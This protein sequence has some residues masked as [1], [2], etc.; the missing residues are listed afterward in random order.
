[1]GRGSKRPRRPPKNAKNNRNDGNVFANGALDDEIDAYHRQRDVIPLD[2]NAA[3]GD[4]SDAEEPVFNLGGD[5]INDTESGSDDDDDDNDVDE[6]IQPNKFSAKIAR[7]KKFLKQKFGGSDDE[8]HDDDDDDDEDKEEQRKAAWGGK[9]S[10]YY[11]ADNADYELQSSDEDLPMEEEAEAVRIQKEKAKFL[12]LEDFG[13]EEADESGSD[14]HAKEKK[15]K[16][17]LDVRKSRERFN[18][19]GFRGETTLESFEEIKIDL[20]SLSKEELMDAVYSSAPELVGLLSELS[21]A[22]SQVEKLEPLVCEVKERKDGAKGK[23][24]HLEV[25]RLLLLTYCQAIVFYLLLKSEGHP[26]QDHPVVGRLVEIKAMMEQMKQIEANIPSQ[27]DKKFIQ[28]VATKSTDKLVNQSEVTNVPTKTHE[29]PVKVSTHLVIDGSLKKKH[30]K[31]VNQKDQVFQGI[32]LQSMEML[33]VRADLEAKLK[34]KGLYDL[35]NSK[36][37][38]NQKNSSKPVNKHLETQDDFDDEVQPVVNSGKQGVSKLSKLIPNKGNK[39]KFVSGDDDLP[40][41]DDIGERR[42]KHELRVLARA[43]TVSMDDD[44]GLGNKSMDIDAHKD[45]ETTDPE[46]DFYKEVKRQRMEKLNAKAALYSRTPVAPSTL[47]TEEGGRRP[48]TYQIEKNK[49][50]TRHRKK[51]TKIPRKK[52]K[53]KHQK[54]V[55]RRKGQ[56]RDIRRPSGPYGG[57]ATGINPNISRSIRFKN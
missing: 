51:L 35:K 17:V 2:A 22:W 28:K 38:S 43:G 48:I 42:R 54:A 9:K 34:Q 40:M 3:D 25:K 45:D 11:D 46:D 53:I 29:S 5:N 27:V 44:I 37:G 14:S 41:R 47:E 10:W 16:A 20:N 18:T 6:D 39:P 32:G 36:N 26:V 33:K 1:M 21:E 55:I 57:E 56:V 15:Q 52:Y 49:G 13:L 24:H 50:L 8:M 4:S 19:E 12:S 23:M 7:T 31:H 30:N